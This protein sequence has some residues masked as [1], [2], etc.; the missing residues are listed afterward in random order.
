MFAII[1][2]IFSPIESGVARAAPCGSTR[3]PLLLLLPM[4]YGGVPQMRPPPAQRMVYLVHTAVT[5]YVVDYTTILNK[6]KTVR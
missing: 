3:T 1:V 5:I 2:F 6:K 4:T